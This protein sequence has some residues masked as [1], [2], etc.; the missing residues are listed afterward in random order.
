MMYRQGWLFWLLLLTGSVHAAELAVS[1]CADRQAL[2]EKLTALAVDEVQRLAGQSVT[3]NL[4]VIGELP[5]LELP[6]VVLL[7]KTLRSRMA[8]TITGK[9]CDRDRQVVVTVWLKVQAMR[10]AWIYGRNARQDSP[11][12]EV[13]P[14]REVIDITALQIAGTELAESIEHKWLRQT[15]YAGR[16]V[17]QRQLRDDLW[18]RLDQQV[19]V[20]VRG[21]GLELRTQ[22]KAMQSGIFGDPIQV[23]VSG[24]AASMPATIAGK[25]EVHVY[26]E[27]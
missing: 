19:A 18:V 23:L 13:A 10:E 9:S 3:I 20:M 8:A 22:G 4:G 5:A 1:A 26:M 12:S 27:M 11:M 17:L 7:S 24:A 21:P 14:H 15:V 25:G 6:E 2:Q 16:P